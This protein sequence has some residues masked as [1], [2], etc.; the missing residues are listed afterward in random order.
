MAKREVEKQGDTTPVEGPAPEAK[1]EVEELLDS[2]FKA[3][4]DLQS[5]VKDLA[6]ATASGAEAQRGLEE[7]LGKRLEEMEKRIGERWSEEFRK[8]AV[9]VEHAAAESKAGDKL[10]PA[11]AKK[12]EAVGEKVEPGTSEVAQAPYEKPEVVKGKVVETPRPSVEV[13]QP[14]AGATPEENEVIKK[15]LSG[16]LKPGEVLQYVKR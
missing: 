13:K 5:A 7:T 2:I 10:M 3:L 11:A 6:T 14:A 1:P 15:I 16:Q 4:A 8:F 9:G 12:P